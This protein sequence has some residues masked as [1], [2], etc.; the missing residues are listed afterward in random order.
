M[1]SSGPAS[2]LNRLIASCCRILIGV[3]RSSW[4][5]SEIS[6]VSSWFTSKATNSSRSFCF[7]RSNWSN[8]QLMNSSL[9]LSSD[10]RPPCSSFSSASSNPS[11]GPK[12]KGESQAACT[13]CLTCST[14]TI[15]SAAPSQG[16]KMD[17]PSPRSSGGSDS[18]PGSLSTL[19]CCQK[20]IRTQTDLSVQWLSISSMPLQMPKMRTRGLC[21]CHRRMA[22]QSLLV[23][24]SLLLLCTNLLT[25]KL[26]M[27]L[28]R[29]RRGRCSDSF[30]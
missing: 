3:A 7:A 18:C 12:A 21:S 22:A 28:T 17:Q 29:L 14:A 6:S 20:S 15:L 23:F 27:V 1:V 2:S 4:M 25:M 8:Q 11:M 30:S 13:D 5:N 16:P 10:T 19:S 26:R 24:S 9:L